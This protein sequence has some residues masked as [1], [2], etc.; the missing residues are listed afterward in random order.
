M[1][2]LLDFVIAAVRPALLR[3][4]QGGRSAAESLTE[5]ASAPDGANHDMDQ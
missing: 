3:G 5:N 2:R 4:N 1:K